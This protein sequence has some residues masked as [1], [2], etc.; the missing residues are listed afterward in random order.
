MHNFSLKKKSNIGIV[1]SQIIDL[2][3]NDALPY[4]NVVIKDTTK[5]IITRG[6][7]DEQRVFSIDKIP[8]RENT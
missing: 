3:T 5:K 6:I 8:F 4:V 1:K 7:T 2:K